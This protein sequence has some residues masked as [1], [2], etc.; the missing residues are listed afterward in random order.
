MSLFDAID[1]AASGLTAKRTR[2]DVTAENLANADTTRGATA[3][4]TSARKSS[5]SRSAGFGAALA[6]A[7]GPRRRLPAVCRSQGSSLTRR[8]TS[9]LRPGQPGRQRKGYVKMPNV[10]SVTEMVDMID[11][12]R[13]YEADVTAMNDRKDDV[14]E[15]PGSAE[16]IPAI[17]GAIGPLGPS[18]WGVGSV[19]SIGS[20]AGRRPAPTRSP[21]PPAATAASAER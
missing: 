15:D 6:G 21:G 14:P 18:E 20:D 13:S 9:C 12:S 2:M 11:E 7:M 19:G 10:N 1:I 17:S 8:P 5:S 3:S 4:P 16:V